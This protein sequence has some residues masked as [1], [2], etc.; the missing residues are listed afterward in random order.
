MLEENYDSDKF[1]PFP[2]MISTFF[3]GISVVIAKF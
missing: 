2:Y 3:F 1:V